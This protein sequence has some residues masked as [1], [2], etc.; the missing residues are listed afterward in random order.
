MPDSRELGA[1][2][3]AIAR[4]EPSLEGQVI[5]VTGGSRGIGRAIV[6]TLSSY[7]ATVCFTYWRH[8]D[9]AGRVATDVT[10]RGGTALALP[11]DVRDFAR[12]QQVVAE[13]LERFGHLDGLVNNAGMT[14]DKALM[15]MDPA[16]WRDVVETNLTGTFNYCRAAIVTLLKQRSGRIVNVTSVSGL[17]GMARQ[18][19]YSASKAGMIGLTKA[20]AKEV[21]GHGVLV[22]AVAP[23]YIDTEMTSQLDEARQAAAQRQILLGRFGRPEEIAHVV[24]MLM[25]PRVS[26]MTGQ[27]ITVD[28]GLG[29]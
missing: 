18:V 27:V 13:T 20:L 12:A 22:N 21:A 6:E 16:D 19:N 24:A 4:Q 17:R 25:D 8:Q 26:Y 28:G 2:V 15:L 11:A 29:L 14:R 10:A 9:L 5:L 7:G 3:D 23:G 1:A